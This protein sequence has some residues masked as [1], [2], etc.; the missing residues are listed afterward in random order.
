MGNVPLA[1]GLCASPNTAAAGS[2]GRERPGPLRE[3]F[4]GLP[5]AGSPM[6]CNAADSS[7]A[8]PKSED[9]RGDSSEGQSGADGT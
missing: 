8:L 4:W 1:G 7:S 6:S 2:A 3:A 5:S 9:R